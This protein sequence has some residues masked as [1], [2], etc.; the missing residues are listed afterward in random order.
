M[1]V[2][3]THV[4]VLVSGHFCQLLLFSGLVPVGKWEGCSC[5]CPI[6]PNCFLFLVLKGESIAGKGVYRFFGR[7]SCPVQRLGP[8]RGC[9]GGFHVGFGTRDSVPGN[10]GPAA[11]A[12]VF[13]CW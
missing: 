10:S 12:D 3:F 1:E 8:T 5:E 13:S 2:S 6:M 9:F 7:A 11:W 4:P